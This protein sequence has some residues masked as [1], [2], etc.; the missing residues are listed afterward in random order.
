MVKDIHGQGEDDGGVLLGSDGVEGLQV[1]QLE[2]GGRLG[3]DQRRLL[4]GARRV[5]LSLRCNHLQIDAHT[6]GSMS[7]GLFM[8]I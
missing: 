4:Q 2:G 1:A 6:V 7:K 5:H 3:D 8:E